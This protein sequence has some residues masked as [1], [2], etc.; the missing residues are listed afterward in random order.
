M[1]EIK[2]IIR[3][4]RLDEVLSALHGVP[5]L[6]GVTV[7]TV[8]GYGRHASGH[9]GSPYGR[10]TMTKIEIVVTQQQLG[11]VVAAVRGAAHTGRAGDGKIFVSDVR[12]AITIRSGTQGAEAL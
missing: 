9:H 11:A 3:T 6:P 5:D 4:D 7:S 2:A 1:H 12:E 10:T 8:D